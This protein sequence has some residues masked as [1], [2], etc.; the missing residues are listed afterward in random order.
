MAAILV[1][2]AMKAVTAVGAPAYTSGVQEWNGTAPNLNSNPTP[3]SAIPAS[4]N[5][6]SPVPARSAVSMAE[7]SN[8]LVLRYDGVLSATGTSSDAPDAQIAVTKAESV[9]LANE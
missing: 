2:A 7:K 3:T 4:S 6:E 1:Q 5:R 9:A 8:D